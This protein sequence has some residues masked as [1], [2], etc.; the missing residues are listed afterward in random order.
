MARYKFHV[1]GKRKLLPQTAL[2]TI[3]AA[4]NH[5]Q[6]LKNTFNRPKFVQTLFSR[7]NRLQNQIFPLK[8]YF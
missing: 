8:T 2:K 5:F 1:R 3:F 6:T 4:Q 7:S